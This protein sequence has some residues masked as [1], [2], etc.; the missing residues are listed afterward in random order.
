T[1]AIRDAVKEM[2][3]GSEQVVA[4]MRSLEEFTR[5]I[6][7]NVNQINDDANQIVSNVKAV[8][9]SSSESQNNLNIL[10]GQLR[11]FKLPQE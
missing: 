4:E 8:S 6:S 2:L 7:D 10:G 9:D 5:S 1:I 3:L 11:R